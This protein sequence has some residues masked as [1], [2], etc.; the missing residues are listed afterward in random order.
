MGLAAGVSLGYFTFDAADGVTLETLE[1]ALVAELAGLVQRPP[2]DVEM[3]VLLADTERWWLQSLAAQDERADLL[4]Q[5]T[6]LYD[7]P[8]FINTYL[9]RVARV[10]SA[11]IVRVAE[12]WLRPESRAV[13]TYE[14][15]A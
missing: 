6:L 4:S 10:T 14:V 12:Q 15:K 9:D 1:A 13:V 7:D 2:T 3:E 8:D 5:Y 11:D